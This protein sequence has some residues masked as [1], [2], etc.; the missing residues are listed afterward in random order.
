MTVLPLV[1][2]HMQSVSHLHQIPRSTSP[3][4]IPPLQALMVLPQ[5]DTDSS[6]CHTHHP[7]WTETKIVL[8]AAFFQ[9]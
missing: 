2:P 6:Y 7:Q 9:T 3:R 4:R 1:G 8:P 5:G